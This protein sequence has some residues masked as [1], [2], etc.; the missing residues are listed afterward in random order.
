MFLRAGLC[1]HLRGLGVTII[2]LWTCLGLVVLVVVVVV[3]AVVVVVVV[4]EVVVVVV[5]VVVTIMSIVTY[6]NSFKCSI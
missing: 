6:S 1:G 3:V 2:N 4:V 5:V